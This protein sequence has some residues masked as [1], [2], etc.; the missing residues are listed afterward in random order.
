[1][2]AAHQVGADD[3]SVLAECRRDLGFDIRVKSA[4]EIAKDVCLLRLY[5]RATADPFDLEAAVAFLDRRERVDNGRLARKIRRAEHRAWVAERRL[6][7]KLLGRSLPRDN[8]QTDGT[9]GLDRDELETYNVILQAVLAGRP[10][11]P[12]QEATVGRLNVK[13]W[14][15]EVREETRLAGSIKK[16]DSA[17][18][19]R[20]GGAGTRG[21]RTA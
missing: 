2:L 13:M 6:R 18:V 9:G 19:T 14:R 7:V 4:R 3:Q 1:M 11:T 15:Y 10:V 12:E 21:P 17:D 20:P 5:E 16:L 8:E